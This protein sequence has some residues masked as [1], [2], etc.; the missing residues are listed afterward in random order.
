MT[1]DKRINSLKRYYRSIDDKDFYI[2]YGLFSSR[3]VYQRG[4]REQIK[5]MKQF[6]QFYE[7]PEGRIIALGKHIH[8]QFEI[9][10]SEVEVHGHF[11]GVLKNGEKVETNFID[12]FKFNK[13]DKI[14]KRTTIF[15]Q[16]QREI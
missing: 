9:T 13:Q 6:R 7:T 8:L 15:P 4:T 10:H 14:T 5:G 2:V 16:G 11:S 3:I 12:T 1:K